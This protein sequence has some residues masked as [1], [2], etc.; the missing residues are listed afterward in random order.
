MDQGSRSRRGWG[1]A[2][3][4]WG[5]SVIECREFGQREIAW[6][7]DKAWPVL[8]PCAKC[9][10]HYCSHVFRFGRMGKVTIQDG[11]SM[12]SDW[13][14]VARKWLIDVHNAV[15][16]HLGKRKLSEREALDAIR[17]FKG[18]RHETP[19]VVATVRANLRYNRPASK[20]KQ[21]ERLNMLVKMLKSKGF[22][23]T[24]SLQDQQRRV[25]PLVITRRPRSCR[26][27]QKREQNSAS[28]S[29]VPQK[30]AKS[31]RSV[32]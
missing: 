29:R 3:W 15:N 8:L 27:L 10:R 31:R 32:R 17:R 19:F 22:N 25:L 20:P 5:H 18:V 16:V 6:I 1:A 30:S 24:M 21:Q 7:F 12:R 2:W 23:T 9:R 14:K 11:R 28:R 26:N 13:R 4:R